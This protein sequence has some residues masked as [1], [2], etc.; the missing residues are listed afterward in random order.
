MGRLTEPVVM[1]DKF[2]GWFALVSVM[3]GGMFLTFAESK[4]EMSVGFVLMGIGVVIC[5]HVVCRR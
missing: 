4:I 2:V 5:Y 1:R 3:L